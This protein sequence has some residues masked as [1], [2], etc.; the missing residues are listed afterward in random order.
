MNNNN[1]N[2]DCV[3]KESHLLLNTFGVHTSKI[4]IFSDTVYKPIAEL[5]S[6]GTHFLLISE[7]SCAGDK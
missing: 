6:H 5:V 1:T 2:K 4:N 7:S 3:S